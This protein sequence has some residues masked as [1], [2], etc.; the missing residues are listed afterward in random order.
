VAVTPTPT[1]TPSGTP[2]AIPTPHEVGFNLFGTSGTWNANSN[3]VLQ[4]DV[5]AESPDGNVGVHIPIGTTMLLGGQPI[6]DFM[7]SAVDPLP[8]PPAGGHVLA[9][10]DFEPN[11]ATFSPGIEIT[12]AFDPA[13]VAAGEEVVIALLNEDGTWAYITGVVNADG[14]ATFTVNHFSIYAVLAVPEGAVPTPTTAPA[15]NGGDEGVDWWLWVVAGVM[16]LVVLILVIAIIA[17]LRGK[18]GTKLQKGT[19]SKKQRMDDDSDMDFQSETRPKK[20]M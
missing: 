7:V 20:R 13:E 10:F 5:D 4:D 3:G 6:E 18:G 1:T 8:D 9:A 11:G 16:A 17:R 12:I 19:R 15:Q 2:T 14:T